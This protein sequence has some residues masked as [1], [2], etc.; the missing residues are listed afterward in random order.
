[1]DAGKL[2]K[3]EGKEKET[4]MIG[5]VEGAEA[6][7]GDVAVGAEVEIDTGDD[8]AAQDQEDIV[9]TGEVEVETEGKQY[10]LLSCTII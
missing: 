4:G 8:V 6:E 10:F 5:I 9:D 1:M 2:K 3:E 7:I